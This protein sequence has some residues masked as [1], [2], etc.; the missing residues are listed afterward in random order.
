MSN[1]PRILSQIRPTLYIGN[2]WAAQ[3][4]SLLLEKD[5]KGVVSLA[6][7]SSP[8][9]NYRKLNIDWKRFCIHDHENFEDEKKSLSS[10]IFPWIKQ[11]EADD[12]AV[13]IHCEMGISRSSACT[14]AY[15]IWDGM[16]FEEALKLVAEKHPI[17]FPSLLVMESFLSLINVEQPNLA[18]ILFKEH[19]RAEL[20]INRAYH[21]T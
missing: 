6:W 1:N 19:K 3:Q 7:W 21:N 18:E 4:N 2:I 17:A 14:I 5:I 20:E 11:M 15:L 8:E 10:D 12:K 9:T 16:S 13:L